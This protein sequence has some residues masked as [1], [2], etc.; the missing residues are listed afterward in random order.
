MNKQQKEEFVQTAEDI[1]AT[2]LRR[3]LEQQ[4]LNEFVV[5][6]PESGDY[7][8]GKTLS[9]AGT[10]ARKVHPDRLTHAIR[11]GHE[12]AIHFGMHAQ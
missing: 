6:E 12:A 9:D 10:A 5:I 2:K 4:H 3:L 1:Y 8:L 7:F 11:V